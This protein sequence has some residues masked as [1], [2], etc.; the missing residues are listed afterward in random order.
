MGLFSSI[1][2]AFK[3]VVKPAV[4]AVDSLFGGASAQALLSHRGISDQNEANIANARE[5]AAFNAHQAQLNRDFQAD[6]ARIAWDRNRHSA[7]TAYT[8]NAYQAA[9][10]RKWQKH[11]SD[12]AHQREI[13]DLRRAGL[14]PILSA[15]YGGASSP[16]GAMGQAPTATASAPAGSTASRPAAR[17]E[18]EW[19]PALA[20]AM[21]YSKNRA[22]V[23]LMHARATES[24]TAAARNAAQANTERAKQAQA[25]ADANLKGGMGSWY[26]AQVDKIDADID[27][28]REEINKIRADT[29]ES[30]ARADNLIAMLSKLRAESSLYESEFWGPLFKGAVDFGPLLLGS[31]GLGAGII[32]WL[33]KRGAPRGL[34][35]Q[36]RRMFGVKK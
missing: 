10:N 31:A 30:R 22:D 36:A 25:Y 24:R 15:K 8:R 23:N 7:R 12:T 21:Q 2:K 26:A 33:T 9:M 13:A 34:V 5:A 16:P 20:T 32:T 6:Q 1:G 14:N 11:M 28:I 29:G 19:T 35:N 3:S 17:S 27:K 4:S 18:D